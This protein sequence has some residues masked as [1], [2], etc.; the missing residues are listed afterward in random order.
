M[1]WGSGPANETRDSAAN[2][3]VESVSSVNTITK[4]NPEMA[5]AV[6]RLWLADKEAKED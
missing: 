2:E 1:K 5:S 4:Q 6:L 3:M